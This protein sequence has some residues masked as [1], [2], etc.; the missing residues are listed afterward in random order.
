MGEDSSVKKGRIVRMEG[1]G[2]AQEGWNSS[3]GRERDSSDGM[4]R[5]S[6]DGRRRIA[7]MEE[8]G[9]IRWKGEG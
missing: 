2:A 3:D 9:Y 1:G 7:Q 4:E 8:R 5:D 6:S